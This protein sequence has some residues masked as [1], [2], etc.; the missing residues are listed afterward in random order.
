M[1][2]SAAECLERL[3]SITVDPEFE[4]VCPAITIKEFE[5]LEQNILSDGEV[6]SPLVVWN[7]IL[8]DGHNR[9]QIILKHPE[10]PFRIKN[11]EF[12]SR[13]AATAW[14][15]SNQLGRRNLTAENKD[16]LIGIQ[17][18]AT[19][20]AH[21]DSERMTGK[22]KKSPSGQNDHLEEK[23]ADRIAKE[24]GISE[25]TVRRNAQYAKGVDAAEAAC[26][27]VKHELLSGAFRPTKKE[28]GALSMLPAEEIPDRIA[29]YRKAHAE[30]GEKKRQARETKHR[31]AP[32]DKEAEK[33]YTSIGELSANMEKPK[34]SN[35]V[36]NVIG[37]IS[38]L[39]QKLILTCEAYI[40]DFPE[41]MGT[42]KP[43]LFQ[44]TED[45][46]EYLNTLHEE[47]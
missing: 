1:N 21:G 41:L 34:Q 7:D 29:E 3:K 16:Y 22:T 43:L 6:T 19:K 12:E 47:E 17:Y 14:I 20:Q 13:F 24:H 39:A 5:Q 37:I 9:R 23:T 40:S 38:E 2:D 45:L 31:Q 44:A 10:T 32:E 4:S 8:I 35:N 28:I 15:C 25:A 42:E 30:R 26:P 46:R 27:G 18:E 36:S 11:I 33:T